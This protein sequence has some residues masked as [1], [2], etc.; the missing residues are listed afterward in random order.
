MYTRAK[1]QFGPF[2]FVISASI[3]SATLLTVEIH[4]FLR[5][6]EEGDWVIPLNNKGLNKL[7]FVIYV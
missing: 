1:I 3:Q 4:E 6:A 7:H 2:C 5:S